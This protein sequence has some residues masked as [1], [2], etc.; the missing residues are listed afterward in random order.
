MGDSLSEYY[1]LSS[2]PD[3]ILWLDSELFVIS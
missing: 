2:K 3:H 1:T